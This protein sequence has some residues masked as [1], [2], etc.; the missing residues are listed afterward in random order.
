MTAVA[1]VM[2]AG[3]TQVFAQQMAPY[4]TGAY[5]EVAPVGYAAPVTPAS[6]SRLQDSSTYNAAS[7]CN[8]CNAVGRECCCCCDCWGHRVA[9]WGEG[10]YLKARDAE[11]AYG[12]P[13]DGPIAPQPADFPIQ[14]GR[15]GVVDQDYEPG[16][17]FGVG[18]VLDGW[19][20]LN[21]QYSRLESV[22]ADRIETAAPNVIR[23]L[24]SHPGTLTA[25]QDFLVA[26]ASHAIQFDLIDV[27]YRRVISCETDH[28]LLLLAGVRYG[29][30]S[31]NFA[32]DFIN[33]GTETV[34][35]EIDFDGVG[36][37]LG[38]EGERYSRGGRLLVY[39]KAAANLLAGTFTAD[40][41]QFQSYDPEVVNTT[42]EAGRIVPVM[43]LEA[44][45]GLQSPCK[46]WRVTSGYVYNSWSNFVKTDH[47][48]KA[49][50]HNNFV[51]PAGDE[52][53]QTLT[54]DGFVL[55]VEGRF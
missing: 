45:I 44:G 13:I 54:F 35:T 15:V 17:R 10:L 29:Q 6:A 24:V 27:D 26:H 47:F 19:S 31:Q 20:S 18:F 11:V 12:V 16:F 33:N 34:L 4:V 8:A 3:G 40:Y 22:S 32:A 38:M 37:R 7:S 53:D 23:S 39:G 9:V 49:V 28:Q 2:V 14:I 48:I 43:E 50:Q 30:L 36:L 5:S 21:V 25:A 52:L 51:E 55:R 42:W 41:R 1:V 46:T